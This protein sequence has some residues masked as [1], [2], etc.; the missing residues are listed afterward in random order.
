MGHT[1]TLLPTGKVLIVGGSNGGGAL[2][3]AELYDVATG[4]WGPA[5]SLT[6]PHEGHTTLLLDSGKVLVTG[7]SAAGITFAI[8]EVESP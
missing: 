6:T 8:T 4:L 7:G 3:T 5:S 1:A 2:A